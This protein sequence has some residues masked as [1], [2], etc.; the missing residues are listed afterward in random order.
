M[1][2]E[3]DGC[4]QATE[5]TL[6]LPPTLPLS[7]SLPLPPSRTPTLPPAPALALLT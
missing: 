4:A 5:L 2:S 1:A 7:L 6:P 3:R